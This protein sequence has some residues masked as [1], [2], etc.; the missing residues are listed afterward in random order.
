MMLVERIFNVRKKGMNQRRLNAKAKKSKIIEK[1]KVN[2]RKGLNER[3]NM[4]VIK[5]RIK[6][7]KNGIRNNQEKSRMK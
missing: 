4:N 5:K 2:R 3:K 7:R 1:K 6:K